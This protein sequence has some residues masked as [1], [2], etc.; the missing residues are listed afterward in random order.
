MLR[1]RIERDDFASDPRKDFDDAGDFE[2]NAY[3]NG[4]VYFF[5]IEDVSGCKCCGQEVVKHV[6]SCG[7]FYGPIE[8]NGMLDYY[9]AQR[10]LFMEAWHKV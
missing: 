1:V 3:L 10:E 4:E 5:I 7:G 2:I 6:D 9:P 8:T